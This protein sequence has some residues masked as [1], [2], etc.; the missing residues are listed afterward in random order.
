MPLETVYYL[1]QTI[2]VVALLVSLIFVGI[3][4]RQNTKATKAASHHAITD[5]FNQINSIIGTD[6]ISARIW[7]L[8]L[9]DLGNLNEDEQMSFNFLCIAYMR[10]FETLYYQKHNG[11]IEAQLFNAEKRSIMWAATFPGFREW[12]ATNEISFSDEFRAYVDQIIVES[13]NV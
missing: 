9:D 12:W 7:R 3:Q 10:V 4:I 11:T 6:P 8:G 13:G 1:G 5:S 2:A